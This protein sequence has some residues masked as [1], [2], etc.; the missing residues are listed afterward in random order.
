[1]QDDPFQGAVK[2]L[3]KVNKIIN[4]ESS[5]LEQL[6]AP[7]KVLEVA[8][9]VRMD[10]GSMKV[11]TGYRSQFN[12]ARGPYKGGIR[13]HQDVSRAEVKALSMWMTWKCAV[14][15]IP[16]GGGKGGIIVNPKVLSSGELERL[17]RGYIQ[18]IYKLLGPQTDV[19][20][21]D[22]YTTP[23]IMGWMMDEYEK[24]VGHHT[25]GMIT[26]KPLSIGGS[27][28]RG[29][30]TA[31][32]GYYCLDEAVKRLKIKKSDVTVAVQGFG[33]AGANMAE[34]ISREGYKIVSVSDSRGI[35]YNSKGLDIVKLLEHKQKTGSVS[36]FADAKNL[37]TDI[38][39]QDVKILVLAAL[40]NAVTLDNV[41]SIKAELIIELANGPITPDADEVL[42]KKN[43]TVVPDILA[44]A[45][46]VGVS[47]LEQVQNAYNYYWK[48][49]DVLTQLEEMMRGSFE[50]SWAQK[51][52]NNT[53][54]RMGTYALAVERVAQAMRDRGQV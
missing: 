44:N 21:P 6:K 32:G 49:Q 7:Q 54:L 4:L 40:E 9:P 38:L 39:E 47:Y 12:N 5:I 36:N 19:P 33:N 28:A 50:Q 1:M 17:S 26:G 16:L 43:I 20:A 3:E 18:Q 37:D 29:Y 13:Y 41:E 23:Q 35:I 53:D 11:F 10:N 42:Y 22:V 45:G 24:L 48:E 30:S 2:Q 8:I 46:G 34:I 51:E 15:G 52:K 25:P 31:Q 27:Q 14:V